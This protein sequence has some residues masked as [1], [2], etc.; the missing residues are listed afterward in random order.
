[1]S[2]EF[3]TNDKENT[4]KNKINHILIND[5]NIEY[6]DFLIGYFRMSGFDK[7]ASSLK[8]IEHTR[9]L[10]GISRDKSTFEASELISKF[11]SEQIAFCDAY[12]ANFISMKELILNK[13]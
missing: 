4:L 5:K 8:N 12:Y 13:K 10:I 1:M 2:S 6:L 3:F 11:A 9:I 7:I